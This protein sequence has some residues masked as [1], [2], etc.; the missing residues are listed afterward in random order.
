MFPTLS[1]GPRSLRP[2]GDRLRSEHR[3]DPEERAAGREDGSRGQPAE[4]A[5]RRD[6]KVGWGLP[7]V[8]I[9]RSGFYFGVGVPGRQ[10]F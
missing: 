3:A 4:A 6:G 5:S 9:V 7:S 2:Y 8:L 1:T 10:T